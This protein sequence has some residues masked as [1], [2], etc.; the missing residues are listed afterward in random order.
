VHNAHHGRAA[1]QQ[2]DVHRELAVALDELLL[3]LGASARSA[4]IGLRMSSAHKVRTFVPSSGS[5]HQLYW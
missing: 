4:G 2:R 1:A 3:A 5:T